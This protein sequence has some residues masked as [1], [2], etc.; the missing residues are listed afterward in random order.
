MK[1]KLFSIYQLLDQMTNEH[2]LSPNQQNRGFIFFPS[3]N[4]NTHFC[5]REA[6]IQKIGVR[7][8]ENC[9]PNATFRF[10]EC[11]GTNLTLSHTFPI[12]IDHIAN[13]V[14]INVRTCHNLWCIAIECM[15]KYSACLPII[16][17]IVSTLTHG[18]QWMRLYISGLANE[19]WLEIN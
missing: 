9:I 6:H 18:I 19:L 3:S 17:Q 10:V 16:T 11:M 13:T 14:R 8:T 1:T 7:M 4:S 12:S 5:Q 2:S 15:L